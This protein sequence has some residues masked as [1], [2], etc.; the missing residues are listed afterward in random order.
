MENYPEHIVM[1]RV[2]QEITEYLAW[3]NMRDLEDNVIQLLQE[4]GFIARAV[5]NFIS[6]GLSL[7][8]QQTHT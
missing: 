8:G 7:Y 3:E 1:I 4:H 5:S 2:T 6:P